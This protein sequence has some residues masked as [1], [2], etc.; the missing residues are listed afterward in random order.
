MM[1]S[2]RSRIRVKSTM[3]TSPTLAGKVALV[4]GSGRMRGTGRAIAVALAQ[5]GCAVAV[6]GSGSSPDSWPLSEREAGWRGTASVADEIRSLGRR[7]E[8]FSADLTR[9]AEIDALFEQVVKTFGRVDILVNN[10]AAPH[11]ADRNPVVAVSDAEWRRVVD[12]KLT[13]A[14][15]ASRAAARAFIAQATGGRIVNVS[16]IAGKIG[17]PEAAAYSAAS[18][19]LHMLGACLAREMAVHNVTVNSLCLGIVDTSRIDGFGRGELYQA[20]LQRNVPLNRAGTPEEVA[21]A[22]VFLC[23]PG[24]DYITGQS[25]NVDGG[26]AIH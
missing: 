2:R 4:T 5:H 3:S 9:S 10:A 16:S 22:V 23:G 13:G 15:Y 7:A 6:H 25:I 24:G 19:G 11:G 17:A 14:F 20:T 8:P 21:R 26:W 1:D 12:V 18:A